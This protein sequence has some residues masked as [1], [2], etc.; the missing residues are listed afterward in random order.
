MTTITVAQEIMEARERLTL[1]FELLREDMT[2][3]FWEGFGE[4]AATYRRARNESTGARDFG[5]AVKGLE[6]DARGTANSPELRRGAPVPAEY[7]LPVTGVRE[8]PP[9]PSRD[10]WATMPRDGSGRMNPAERVLY[11]V[12]ATACLAVLMIVG[13]LFAGVGSS[14]DAVP[15]G[16]PAAE[17]VSDADM[18]TQGG[19][20]SWAVADGCA[21]GPAE[22]DQALK[23]VNAAASAYG[24]RVF[25]DGTI[26]PL[27]ARY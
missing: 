8:F 9:M 14:P 26:S 21:R 11:A 4:A 3:H 17:I 13:F 20:W 25:E 27:G 7:P 10:P 19:Y 12:T 16:S 1:P 2:A 6:L 5:F 23:E 24:L 18:I 22:C 15:A